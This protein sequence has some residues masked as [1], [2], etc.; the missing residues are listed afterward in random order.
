MNKKLMSGQTD[1]ELPIFVKWMEF[2]E[3]LL[4]TTAKSPRKSRLTFSQRIEELAL[5]VAEDLVEARY[6]SDKLELLRR[7][8]L[9]LE[10]AMCGSISPALNTPR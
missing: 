6:S 3:W 1:D 10:N 4:L 8:N 7:V 5:N 2:L 9:K